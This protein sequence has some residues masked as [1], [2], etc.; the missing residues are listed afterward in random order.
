MFYKAIEIFYE[1]KLIPGELIY[2]YYNFLF[3]KVGI[4]SFWN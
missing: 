3:L 2:F 1:V 4:Y